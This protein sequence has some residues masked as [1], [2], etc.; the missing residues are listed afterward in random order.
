[1]PQ[2][3]DFA[4]VQTLLLEPEPSLRLVRSSLAA[5]GFRKIAKGDPATPDLATLELTA[6]DL[7]LVHATME[8]TAGFDLIQRIRNR[9]FRTNPFV[10]AL[11][12]TWEPTPV[13]IARAG[14]AGADGVLA[15]PFSMAS[16]RDVVTKFVDTPRPWIAAPVY[17]GPDRRRD[18][19]AGSDDPTVE[20]PNTLRMK[21]TG[22][23]MG[24]VAEQIDRAWTDVAMVRLERTAR[25]AGDILRNARA[26]PGADG[27][28]PS[29]RRL[30]A[31]MDELVQRA[32]P[33]DDPRI[34]R[35]A[36]EA[37]SILRT[38]FRAPG[39]LPSSLSAC[40][41]LADLLGAIA[42]SSK[43]A[44]AEAGAA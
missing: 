33:T 42:R 39:K 25:L 12:T 36:G 1:M 38:A 11:V 14:A 21:A 24:D 6:F 43:A 23:P 26:E 4:D 8:E 35:V 40:I 37:A 41:T 10:C 22:Q 7:I 17:V 16:I 31:M 32:A 18:R 27:T 5:M 44:P 15:K 3:P 19:E 28:E 20:V 30:V 2:P 29:L 9:R 34:A 13:V